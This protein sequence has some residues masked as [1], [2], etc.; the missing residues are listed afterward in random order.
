ML[1]PYNWWSISGPIYLVSHQVQVYS[2]RNKNVKLE[3]HKVYMSRVFSSIKSIVAAGQQLLLQKG[4]TWWLVRQ[5]AL[6]CW[7]MTSLTIPT[8]FASLKLWCPFPLLGFFY[9]FCGI[10][11]EKT[12]R[13]TDPERENS[14]QHSW[15]G[16]TQASNTPF[17][18]TFRCGSHRRVHWV[19]PVG[20]THDV[21][22]TPFS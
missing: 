1:F 7:K 20:P 13:A 17:H 14:L 12:V 22:L 8:A 5:M 11:L 3:S 2:P 4:C 19:I 18:Y 6:F 16:D 21:A 9:W 10:I 15:G